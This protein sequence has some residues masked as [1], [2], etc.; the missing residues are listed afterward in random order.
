MVP[1]VQR[2]LH[3]HVRAKTAGKGRSSLFAL[4]LVFLFFSVPA[5][6]LS[7]WT[8][9][10]SPMNGSFAFT[11]LPNDQ[12]RST[13]KIVSAVSDVRVNELGVAWSSFVVKYSFT[14]SDTPHSDIHLDSAT[15]PGEQE[16]A[17]FYS[18]RWYDF[19]HYDGNELTLARKELCRISKQTNKGN[20]HTV[21]DKVQ[22]LQRIDLER[23][24]DKHPY[25]KDSLDLFKTGSSNLILVHF[26]DKPDDVHRL[27]FFSKMREASRRRG[28]IRTEPI[29]TTWSC[30]SIN[31]ECSKS[32]VTSL[33][34]AIPVL[35]GT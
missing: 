12:N 16:R 23:C 17:R 5:L 28:I 2:I 7:E 8:K 29:E 13:A 1:G 24:K 19:S 35:C 10:L 31:T 14:G 22:A 34:S 18:G 21:M 6:D 27:P 9:R 15:F 26:G 25:C 11:S 20:P 33:D 30:L 4:L 32:T 3:S